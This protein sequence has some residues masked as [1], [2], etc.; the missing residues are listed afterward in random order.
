MASCGGI[1]RQGISPMTDHA[2]HTHGSAQAVMS[3][4]GPPLKEGQARDPVCGMAVD[5]A[6][7]KHSAEHAG[8]TYYFCC[9]GCRKKF[10]ADPDKVLA[11]AGTAPSERVADPVCGMKVD[12]ATARHRAEQAGKTF[13]FCSER[14]HEK[15]AADPA[16]YLAEAEKPAA[17]APPGAIY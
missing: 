6:T 3:L 13:Y 4:F 17:S 11:K 8:S 10:L 15:F 16:R 7:A 14:C 12:P 1:G 5:M 2:S 9:D